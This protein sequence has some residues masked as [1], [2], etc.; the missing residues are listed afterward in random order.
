METLQNGKRKKLEKL[1]YHLMDKGLLVNWHYTGS[2]VIKFK[3]II[4]FGNMEKEEKE[5]VAK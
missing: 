2:Y 1:L 3:S 5:E 4:D